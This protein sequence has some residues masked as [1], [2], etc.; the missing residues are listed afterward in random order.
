MATS[1]GVAINVHRILNSSPTPHTTAIAA[2]TNPLLRSLGYGPYSPFTSQS[3]GSQ[4]H[5]LDLSNEESKRRLFNKLLYRSKQ[6]GFLEWDLVL[7]KWVEENIHSMNENGVKALIDVLDLENPDLWKWVSGQEQ[8]PESVS[9]N[10]VFAA[11]REKV[12]KNLA[13]FCS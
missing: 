11:V 1:R 2:R 6:R 9:I 10:P 13:T 4:S 3:N 5:D 7:G 8:P 12:I